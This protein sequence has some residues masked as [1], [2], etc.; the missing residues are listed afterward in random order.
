MGMD[1]PAAVAAA[2]GARAATKL[3]R[4][5]QVLRAGLAEYLLVFTIFKR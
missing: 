2:A 3:Q 4:K 1:L 5:W